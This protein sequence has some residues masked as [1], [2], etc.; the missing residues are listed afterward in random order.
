MRADSN[1]LIKAMDLAKLLMISDRQVR[2]LAQNGVLKKTAHGQYLFTECIQGYINYVKSQ[3]EGDVD[4]KDEKTKEEISKLRADIELKNLKIDE[5]RNR[6]HDSTIVEN[7]MTTMLTNF[8][9][10]LLSISNKLAPLLITCDNLRDIQDIIQDEILSVLTE[11][12]EY[13]PEMFRNKN[14]VEEDEDEVE[15]IKIKSKIKNKRSKE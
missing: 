3:N 2:N 15:N 1:Q 10:K 4:L 11:L 13:N 5:Q 9:G 7:V 12:S 6:L 14:S 8:K